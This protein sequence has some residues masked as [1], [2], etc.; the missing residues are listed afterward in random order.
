MGEYISVTCDRLPFPLGVCPVCGHG[1]KFTRS[2]TEINPAQLFGDHEYC[3][4]KY[5]PCFVCD[6]EDTLAYI[7]MVGERHY[8]TP[9]HFMQEARI[10]GISKRIPFIPKN[11]E[12]GKTVLY[13]AHNK[14][15]IVQEPAVIREAEKIYAETTKQLF[16][17]S[18]HYN[19]GIFTAFIPKRIEKIYWQSEI[20]NMSD[21]DKEKLKKRGITPVGVPDGDRDHAS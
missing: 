2:M 10:Q 16:E 12:L 14:A 6:P 8:P 1:I 13:L 7:M 9:E 20:D 19:L 3:A 15:C 4:D 17:D 5:H 11:M 18:N 21:K